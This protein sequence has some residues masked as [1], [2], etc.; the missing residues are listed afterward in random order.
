MRIVTDSTADLPK[1]ILEQYGITVVPLRVLVDGQ[2]YRDGIDLTSEDFYKRLPQTKNLPTTSQPSPGEFTAAYEDLIR[3]GDSV[4]SIHISGGLSGTMHSAQLA[5][6]MVE[7]EVTVIDSRTTALALGLIVLGAARAAQEGKSHGEVVALVE[8]LIKKTQ[9]FF[10]LDTLEYLQKGGRIG[11]GGALLGS[12]LNVKPILTVKEGIVT[13]VDKVR[14]EN[15]ALE[16]MLQLSREITGGQKIIC[17]VLH[18]NSYARGM[19]LHERVVAE[20]NTTEIL[21]SEISPVIGAHVGPGALGIAFYI[22]E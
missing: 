15:K 21:I 7:G 19:K 5:V 11:K 10:V 20:F 8:K 6:T 9:L 2:I 3:N 18:G 13:P 14:G 1:D 4:V 22:V 12:L 17:G 16:R